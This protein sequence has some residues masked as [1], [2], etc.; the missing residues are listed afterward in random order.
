MCTCYHAGVRTGLWASINTNFILKYIYLVKCFHK[1]NKFPAAGSLVSINSKIFAIS[2]SF[3]F[4]FL[5]LMVHNFTV[6]LTYLGYF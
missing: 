3:S 4:A 6:K 1:V 5:S 2:I